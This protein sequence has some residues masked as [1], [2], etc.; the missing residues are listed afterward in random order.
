MCEIH[1]NFTATFLKTFHSVVSTL[2]DPFF[3][4]WIRACIPTQLQL[5]SLPLQT[6][7]HGILQWLVTGVIV[8]LQAVFYITRW[9]CEVRTVGWM[10]QHWPSKMCDS[11]CDTHTCVQLALLWR[12]NTSH[13]FLAGWI[14]QRQAFKLHIVAIQWSAFSVVPPRHCGASSTTLQFVIMCCFP[15]FSFFNPSFPLNHSTDIC[16]GFT[17]HSE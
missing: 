15:C 5:L 6:L 9:R 14:W 1:S 13:F 17:I 12:C 2:V 11:F 3:Q 8:S 4:L 7:M 10:W 16:S